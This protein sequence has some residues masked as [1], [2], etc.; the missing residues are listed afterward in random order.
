MRSVPVV[1][2]TLA[3]MARWYRQTTERAE[4]QEP[5]AGGEIGDADRIGRDGR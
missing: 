5:V 1:G 2:I 3:L 4:G